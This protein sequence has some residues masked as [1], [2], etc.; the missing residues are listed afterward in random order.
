M[1]RSITP[2]LFPKHIFGSVFF[3]VVLCVC[4]CVRVAPRRFSPNS[5]VA[6]SALCALGLHAMG[7]GGSRVGPQPDSGPQLGNPL[8]KVAP[9]SFAVLIAA[10]TVVPD[11]HEGPYVLASYH[12]NVTGGH[13]GFKA[14]AGFDEWI[15][16]NEA[17]M[18]LQ[19]SWATIDFEAENAVDPEYMFAYG[20]INGG[21]LQM[22]ELRRV[23]IRAQEGMKKGYDKAFKA[24]SS[25]PGAAQVYT[26]IAALPE[27]RGKVLQPGRE[28]REQ[29]DLIGL[30]KGALGAVGELWEYGQQA[31]VASGE[32]GVAASWSLKKA[33]PKPACSFDF[34]PNWQPKAPEP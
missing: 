7:C 32:S 16:T 5:R 14:T 3:G 24:A 21:G 23:V 11:Q 26:R 9:P 33:R 29:L 12:D 2:M 31:M 25:K 20:A 6:N 34:N 8:A 4:V 27:K 18:T 1:L 13:R 30:Y 10:G 17:I 19:T 15:A 22:S 28:G